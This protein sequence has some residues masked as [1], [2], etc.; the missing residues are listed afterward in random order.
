MFPYT[1]G[2]NLHKQITL[3]NPQSIT[4]TDPFV[5]AFNAPFDKSRITSC[6]SVLVPNFELYDVV[7]FDA[8][9]LLGDEFIK[10]D[11]DR[12]INRTGRLSDLFYYRFR[13][14]EAIDETQIHGACYD[15]YMMKKLLLEKFETEEK[16]KEAVLGRTMRRKSDI[17]N[18]LTE[19]VGCGCAQEGSSGYCDGCKCFNCKNPNG[20]KT[21]ESLPVERVITTFV[22][23]IE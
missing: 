21:P 20:S 14:K 5:V 13:D 7:W 3:P 10:D 16:L 17:C 12:V 11:E 15:T 19:C 9:G 4:D 8:R 18:C 22:E 6:A 23:F 2:V 1:V